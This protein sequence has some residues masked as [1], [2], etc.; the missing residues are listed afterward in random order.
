MTDLQTRPGADVIEAVVAQGDLSKLTP[1][2]RV[3]YY[4]KVCDS[5]GLNPATRP[6]EYIVL[7][8][9]MVLYARKEASDQLRQSRGVSVMITGREKV[10]DIYVVTAKA[11]ID[12]R[13]D[14]SIGAVNIGG[15]KGDALA[16]A[17][18]KAETKAKRRVTL[19]IC[20]LGF[21]DETEVE[22]IPGAKPVVVDAQTGEIKQEVPQLEGPHWIEDDKTR[23]AFWAYWSK[24]SL[25]QADIHTALGVEH[26]NEFKGS[27]AD[28]I[29]KINAWVAA[30]AA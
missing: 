4:L 2:Q 8:G 14:E 19:S 30:K 20:G 7:N 13:T 1:Q 23:A 29:A 5:L 24:Q 27:K 3:D 26:V 25:S 6:F 28:A 9:R 15:L 10:E 11:T 22:T 17:L 21:S 12:W 16:N 18:M